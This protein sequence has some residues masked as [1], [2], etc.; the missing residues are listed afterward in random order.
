ME[1]QAAT[2][3]FLSRSETFGAGPVTH[4][5]T[6]G[7]HV[8]LAGDRAIKLKRAI[9]YPYL[10]YSTVKQRR[11]FCQREVD[12]NRRTAPDI[13]L[14]ARPIIE[15]D[16][17]LVFGDGTPADAVDWVVVMR[18]F[19]K[20]AL[21]EEMRK[22]GSLSNG[23]MAELGQALYRFHD[24]A[25]VRRDWGGAS[26]MEA[27]V[28]GSA[29]ML[30][31]Y[32]GRPFDAEI[33]E[34]FDAACQAELCRQRKCLDA[35]RTNG[36]VRRCHGDLH[37]NNI[38]MWQGKPT[39]F[40]AIEFNDAL[41]TIDVLYDLAF[42]VMDLD[43]HS[44]RNLANTLLNSYLWE[45]DY[46][47]GLELL[48]LFLACRG[49]VRAHVTAT[50]SAQRDDEPHWQA[51]A[52]ANRLLEHALGYLS[53]PGPTLIAIGGLSGTGKSTVARC[54]APT[55]GKAPG[56]AVL[57]SD[58]IRKRML[59]AA[60]GEH[61]SASAYSP[62]I[63]A[64]VYDALDERAARVLQA[65]HS[66][67]LDAVFGSDDERLRLEHLARRTGAI[68]K[69]IWLTASAAACE[70]RISLRGNDASDA[71][72]AVFRRQLEAIKAPAMWPHVSAESEVDEVVAEARRRVSIISGSEH[73]R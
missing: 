72:V 61:L 1:E 67:V 6:H 43:R 32:I 2:I 44:L 49:A 65:G 21:L 59:G 69:P 58:S 34:A 41:A 37:L 9:C 16:G 4:L 30:K 23:L 60:E 68:L 63:S 33:V 28:A 39:P 45:G 8:F 54:L 57:R 7:A 10:D 52:E 20:G 71:D 51:D 62:Q 70:R 53:G 25:E 19:P 11:E 66:V 24:G 31:T 46:Y 26:A 22:A 73:E 14:E 5:E 50:R 12:L 42:L 15:R 55:I 40:D 29:Q 17:A 3:A 18:R 56:A 36:F 35:R 47:A 64:R 13:Y 48:P 27:V 38:C